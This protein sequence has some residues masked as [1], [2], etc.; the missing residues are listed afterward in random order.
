MSPNYTANGGGMLSA[1]PP[2]YSYSQSTPP[3][4]PNNKTVGAGLAG[5]GTSFLNAYS[6]APAQNGQPMRLGS[7]TPSP[8]Q[9]MIN[10]LLNGGSANSSTPP[11]P[12][13]FSGVY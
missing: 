13:A 6:Q 9:A 3:V 4:A 5:L 10:A 1:P 12:D 11:T 7:A 2:N 8:L